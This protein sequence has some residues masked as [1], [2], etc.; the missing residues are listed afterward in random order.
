[1][2]ASLIAGLADSSTQL[3]VARVLQGTGASLITPS[4]LGIVADAFTEGKEREMALGI[5]G[6]LAGLAATVGVLAGGLL[7]DG[8]GWSWIFYVNVPIGVVLLA[9]TAVV[10]RENRMRGPEAKSTQPAPCR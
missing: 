3:I 8:P 2:V 1:M 6:A 10:L 5:Y 7:T 4:A 9:L